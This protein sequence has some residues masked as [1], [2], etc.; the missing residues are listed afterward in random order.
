MDLEKEDIYTVFR[1]PSKCDIILA[2][3]SAPC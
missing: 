1:A 2:K 3:E